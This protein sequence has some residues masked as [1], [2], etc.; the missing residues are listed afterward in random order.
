MTPLPASETTSLLGS[1]MFAG[2]SHFQIFG[3]TF[4][5]IHVPNPEPRRDRTLSL[6]NVRQC[7]APSQYFTGR[8]DTLSKLCKIFSATIMTL[9]G[10]DEKILAS[11]VRTIGRTETV[12]LLASSDEALA[13]ALAEKFPDSKLRANTL[14]VLEN[15]HPSLVLDDHLPACCSCPVL[16]TSTNSAVGKLASSPDNAF[17]LPE[18][19]KQQLMNQVQGSIQKA[20]KPKQHIVT[21]VASGGTGK[22]QV[23]LKFVLDNS[24]RFSNIWFFD[25]TSDTTLTTDFK[26]L[27]KVAGVG[28]E[29]KSVRDFL[30]RIDHNWLC[31]FDN[32][33]DKELYLK[34]YIPSCSHG[35]IIITSRLLETSEMDT[36]GCHIAFGDLNQDDAIELL[37]KHAHME[38][39]E[40]NKKL[41]SE[42]VDTLGCHALAVSTAGA[43]ILT[44]RTCTLATT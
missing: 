36:P 28:Q 35:N 11:F 30:A 33:D 34:D 22:T 24:S 5:V 17:Q 7:P 3:S 29:V 10:P 21:L 40:G 26:A 31:I 39:S 27:G 14:L 15:A 25:A 23:V 1:Q 44:T 2:A 16:I 8:Q 41:A 18:R 4:Q 38:S 19:P 37:L 9:L 12:Y 6:S 20:L 43:Y 32:A 42:I 13:K